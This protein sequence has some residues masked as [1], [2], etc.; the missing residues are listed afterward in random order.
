[1]GQPARDPVLEAETARL[2]EQAKLE[3]QD[4]IKDRVSRDT[5]DAALRFGTAMGGGGQTTSTL[6]PGFMRFF[7]GRR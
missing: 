6:S 2:R 4:A 7:G 1:M 3:K 5:R